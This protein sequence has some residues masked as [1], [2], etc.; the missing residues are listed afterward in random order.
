MMCVV[1]ALI[2]GTYEQ[3][4]TNIDGN[5][6]LTRGLKGFDQSKK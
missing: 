3:T 4:I 1:A 5:S 2:A 6:F